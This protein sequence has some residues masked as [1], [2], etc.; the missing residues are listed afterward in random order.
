MMKMRLLALILVSGIS[1]S[2]SAEIKSYNGWTTG[3]SLGWIRSSFTFKN[4][5]LVKKL[6]NYNYASFGL[7]VDWHHT[8]SN[9]LYFGFG[10]GF[11]YHLGNP[12]QTVFKNLY[13]G[14]LTQGNL[15]SNATGIIKETRNF[16]ADV[17]WRI[18]WNFNTAVIY[19]LAAVKTTQV[20]RE[21]IVTSADTGL[22]NDHKQTEFFWAMGPGAGFDIKLNQR[23]SCGVEY[24]YFFEQANPRTSTQIIS[25]RSHDLR[26]RLSYHF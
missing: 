6:D 3:L 7:H 11:G 13:A 2:V 25:P 17:A 8:N 12:S 21:F 9:Q 26:G 22:R 24:R 18:G 10:S 16:Y 1:Q 4:P 5:S 19:G 15:F 23:F 14:T 20:G